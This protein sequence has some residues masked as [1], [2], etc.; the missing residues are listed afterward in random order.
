MEMGIDPDG[1]EDTV[2]RF[3][4]FVRQGKDEDFKRGELF[5]ADADLGVKPN[6]SLGPIERAPYYGVR[7]SV[8]S[9]GVGNAGLVTDGDARVLHV[10]GHAIPGLYAAGNSAA[11]LDG[12]RGYDGGLFNSR[13]MTFGFLAAQHASKEAERDV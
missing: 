3:N 2:K 7:L 8:A 1:L 13:G 6:P 11:H 10:W 5:I 4:E 9:V 12:K